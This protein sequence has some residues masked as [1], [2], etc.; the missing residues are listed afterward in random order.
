MTRPQR[1]TDI[2]GNIHQYEKEKVIKDEKEETSWIL[3]IVGK[4]SVQAFVHVPT[5]Q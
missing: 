2:I 4:G 5:N 3:D 1:P